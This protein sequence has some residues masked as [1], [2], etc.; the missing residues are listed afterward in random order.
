LRFF[1]D[2]EFTCLV[3]PQLISIG[4][5]S[6]DGQ[7]FYRELKDTW[8]L[9]GCSLFVLGWVLPWLSEGKAGNLLYDR[10]QS[11]LDLIR[12]ETASGGSQL[13]EQKETMLK[14]HLEADSELMDQFRFLSG[15]DTSSLYVR[16]NPYLAKPLKRLRPESILEGD[17]V[18][19]RIHV[20]QDLTA[21]L[22]GFA[23]DIT[24]CV[25]SFYDKEMFQTMIDQRFNFER[26]PDLADHSGG[27]H[28]H[29]VLDDARALRIGCLADS[30]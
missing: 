28:L 26:V 3:R 1:L 22:E 25:D 12:Y 24:I 19:P 14:Q 16:E 21:W 6:E 15:K 4:M 29:H 9:A 20:A 23:D 10:L 30:V 11:A 18:Q 27:L 5:V 13:S 8:T 2:T 7:E 17:Q